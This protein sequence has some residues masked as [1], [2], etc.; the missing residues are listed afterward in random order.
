MHALGHRGRWVVPNRWVWDLKSDTNSIQY[1]NL[2][3]IGVC[4]HRP[5]MPCKLSVLANGKCPNSQGTSATNQITIQ[6]P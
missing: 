2:D 4:K 3:T 5:N 6:W 1:Q